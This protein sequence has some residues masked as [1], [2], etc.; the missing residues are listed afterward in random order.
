MD[1]KLWSVSAAGYGVLLTT[2]HLLASNLINWPESIAT[3]RRDGR[4]DL[5]AEA[6]YSGYSLPIRPPEPQFQMATSKFQRSHG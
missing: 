2:P 6:L 3:I 4:H 1:L 5:N